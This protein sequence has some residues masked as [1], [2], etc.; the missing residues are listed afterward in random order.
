[1]KNCIWKRIK[2]I[3]VEK[4]SMCEFDLKFA[5]SAVHLKS[6]PYGIKMKTKPLQVSYACK[7]ET[8]IESEYLNYLMNL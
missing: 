4:N 3:L 8:F 6:Y 2:P 7:G 5:T 1:M